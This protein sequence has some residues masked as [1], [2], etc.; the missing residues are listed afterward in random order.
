MQDDLPKG[1]KAGA[2]AA[3]AG[4][5]KTF[6]GPA[7][8]FVSAAL[9]AGALVEDQEP[10]AVLAPAGLARGLDFGDLARLFACAA[11]GGSPAFATEDGAVVFYVTGYDEAAPAEAQADAAAVRDGLEYGRQAACKKQMM[12]I[13]EMFS[14]VS[15]AKQPPVS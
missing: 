3:A 1:F 4:F 5:A 13:E 8:S 11:G 9:V 2:A 12:T 14:G 10:F 7:E 6:S 15:A